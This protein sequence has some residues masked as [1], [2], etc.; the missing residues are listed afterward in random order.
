MP[1][2]KKLSVRALAERVSE[3]NDGPKP[4]TVQKAKTG[5]AIS[6]GLRHL[7]TEI[8]LT[9]LGGGA[10]VGM[11]AGL[12]GQAI[13]SAIGH[14]PDGTM[15]AVINPIGAPSASGE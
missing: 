7:Q 14:K 13:H 2:A 6:F 12:N 1:E 10:A 8:L 3:I 5:A 4:V 9:K 15:L 11:L